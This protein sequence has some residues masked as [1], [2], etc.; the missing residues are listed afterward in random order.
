MP[1]R[2][3]ALSAI[4]ALLA[5]A[6]CG[7][8]GTND[9]GY[10]SGD[11]VPREI[12]NAVDRG[13]PVELTGT[14]LQGHD[15]DLSSTRGK[16][17]VVNVWGSWCGDCVR[18]ADFLEAAHRQLGAAV[19]FVGIDVRDYS[20]DPALAFERGHHI[21]YPS[22][23]SPKGTAT[24]AFASSVSPRTTPAT[25]VLDTQGRVAAIIGGTIPSTLTLVEVVHDVQRMSRSEAS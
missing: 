4:L 12:T 18:E 6:G 5:L 19:P 9:A 25:L 22:V 8:S 13:D 7:M 3:T 2:L 15:F 23:Y 17:T 24:L 11:G 1:R 14:T 21:T 20:R 10:I 16:V